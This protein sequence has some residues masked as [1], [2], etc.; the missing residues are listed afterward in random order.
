MNKGVYINIKYKTKNKKM[1][2]EWIESCNY[3]FET[4]EFLRDY[5]TTRALVAEDCIGLLYVEDFE[6]KEFDVNTYVNKYL[7][8]KQKKLY[9]NIIDTRVSTFTEENILSERTD[10]LYPFK[11]KL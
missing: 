11:Y 10:T 2:N 6:T 1:V 4:D 9:G 5:F 3:S 8:K 7:T